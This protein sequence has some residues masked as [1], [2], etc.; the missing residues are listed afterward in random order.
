MATFSWHDYLMMLSFV[1]A[2]A[3]LAIL[4][5]EKA[6]QETD[7]EIADRVLF[8]MSFAYWLVYCVSATALKFVRPEW[9]TVILSVKLTG[10]LSYLLTATCVLSLPLHR[11]SIQQT[12]GD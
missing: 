4:S 6:A 7:A 9:E 11:V 1:A 2:I 3:G 5:L 12:E 10:V 8:M